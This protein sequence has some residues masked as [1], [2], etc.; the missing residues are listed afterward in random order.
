[1]THQEAFQQALVLAI[2]AP[3]NRQANKAIKL[4][5]GMAAQFELTE[6]QIILCKFKALVQLGLQ[7]LTEEQANALKYGGILGLTRSQVQA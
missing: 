2:T 6:G 3:T 5:Q 4:A 1:M 7:D